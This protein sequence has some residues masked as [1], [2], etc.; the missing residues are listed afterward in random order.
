MRWF[1][2]YGDIEK[3]RKAASENVYLA[4]EANKYVILLYARGEEEAADSNGPLDEVVDQCAILNRLA[5]AE[6]V[7]PI[8]IIWS[9][10]QNWKDG[11]GYEI[12]AKT[13]DESL[14]LGCAEGKGQVCASLPPSEYRATRNGSGVTLYDENLMLIGAFRVLSERK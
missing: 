10:F 5:N 1:D 14:T 8:K 13:A 12:E 6:D 9:I 4:L 7:F 3:F 2:R 11:T